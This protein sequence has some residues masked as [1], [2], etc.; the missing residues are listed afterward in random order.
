MASV[1]LAT[2]TPAS[3]VSMDAIDVSKF[4]TALVIGKNATSITLR[5]GALDASHNVTISGTGLTYNEAGLVTGGSIDTLVVVDVPVIYTAQTFTAVPAVT[6]MGWIAAGNTAAVLNAILN[7]SDNM[8]G[9]LGADVLRGQDGNDT[10]LGD[11]GADTIWGGAGDDV[12]RGRIEAATAQS[13]LANPDGA[14]YLRGEGGNDVIDGAGAFDDINGNQGN[15]TIHGGAGNDWVVGGQDNDVLFGDTGD[16]LV[17]GNLGNDTVSGGDGNDAVRGGQGDDVLDGGAGN[18][19][20][21]GDR[22]SDT[23]TGGAGADVFHT[24]VGAGLDRVTDF[25]YAEGDRVVVD[26]PASYTAAQVGA[27]TVITLAGGDTMVL[28]G[29]T[30]SSLTSGWIAIA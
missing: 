8:Q 15:D 16:D 7:G 17:Y 3:G 24:F 27:D 4:N 19:I 30:L 22:G 2:S 13:T 10:I 29:V 20:L 5:I 1:I 14:N 21:W 11:I 26:A 28:A 25:K 23:V 18:D 9:S 6:F 12:I